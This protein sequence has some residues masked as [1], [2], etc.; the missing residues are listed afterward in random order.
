MT[1]EALLAR[2]DAARPTRGG[3]TARCPAH[4]D[5]HPSLSVHEGERGLLLKC[6][7]GCSLPAIC[8]ALGV[9]VRELFYDMQPD[10]RPRRTAVHQ[11]KPRRFDWRQVAGAYEDHVLGLRLRAEAVLEAAKGLHVSEWSDDDFGSAIGAMATAYADVEEADRLE[12]IAF[13]LRLRGLEKEKQHASSC[14]AA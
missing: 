6:W 8:A 11:L 5:R 14:S 13:D 9:A 1:I 12:A 3:W 4:E 7:A 2:L 10:S